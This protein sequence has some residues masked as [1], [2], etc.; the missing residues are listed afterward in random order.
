MYAEDLEMSLRCWQRGLRV[1]YVPDAVI[2]H[3]YEFSR[4][5]QKYF[6]LERNRGIVLL[7]LLEARTLALLAPA[8]LATEIGIALLALRGGW[9]PQKVQS[10]AWLWR[11]RGWLRGRRDRLQ[12]ERTVADRD[13]AVRFVSR[14]DPKNLELPSSV[15]PLN[16]ALAVYWSVTRRLL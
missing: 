16:W 4:N 9:W 8:L 11:N 14:L 3:H 15:R 12:A 7:S 6:L 10:W 1:V 13:M 2:Y 5:P